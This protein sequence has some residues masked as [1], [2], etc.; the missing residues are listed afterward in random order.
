MEEVVEVEVELVEAASSSL[1]SLATLQSVGVVVRLVT[2]ESES[3]TS[4]RKLV[5]GCGRDPN[6]N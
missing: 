5:R 4:M 2:T 6:Y 1:A 3:T